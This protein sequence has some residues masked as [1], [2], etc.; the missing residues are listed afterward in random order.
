MKYFFFLL[1]FFSFSILSAQEIGELA[2]EK[3][4]ETFPKHAWG[5]N[6]MF[7]DGGF[8]LGGFYN[9]SLTR[10][11]TGFADFSLSESK[12][13]NEVEV[14]DYWGEPHVLNKKNRVFLIPLS[15]GLQ[16]RL[17]A[18][19]ITDNLRPYINAGAGPSLV[20][21]TPYEKE[22]FSS[23]K[24]AQNNLALGGYIGL[25]A[26]FGLSKTSLAGINIRY[27]LIHMFSHGVENLEGKYRNDLGGIFITL[28]LG[29]MY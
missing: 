28:N 26:N 16:Q 1:A 23:W 13:E 19:S 14:Y 7:S 22:F 25:G 27:Y 3:A 8:G 21:T 24:Y 29:T 4:P 2:E 10:T 12:D 9:I 18:S 17:F 6:L 11:L 15:L 5:A 20:V